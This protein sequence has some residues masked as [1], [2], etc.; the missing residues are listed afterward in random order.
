M[1][2]MNVWLFLSGFLVI[3]WFGLIGLLLVEG[4]L[5]YLYLIF[6]SVPLLLASAFLI[7]RSKPKPNTM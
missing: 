7:A 6:S 4:S 5:D 3:P 1:K 2:G